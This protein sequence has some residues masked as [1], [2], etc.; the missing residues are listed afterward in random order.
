MHAHCML[1]LILH[2]SEQKPDITPDLLELPIDLMGN[3]HIISGIN[4]KQGISMRVTYL[5][6]WEK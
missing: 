2:I 4:T 1:N 3:Q 6:E 5:R